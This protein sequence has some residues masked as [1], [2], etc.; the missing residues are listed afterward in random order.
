MKVAFDISLLGAEER[1]PQ[2]RTGI[3]KT[4]EAL[5]KQLIVLC[6]NQSASPEQ[7]WTLLP[8]SS[9]LSQLYTSKLAWQRLL[10]EMNVSPSTLPFF[11][12]IQPTIIEQQLLALQERKVHKKNNNQS[13]LIESTILS[14]YRPFWKRHLKQYSKRLSLTLPP[15]TVVHIPFTRDLAKLPSTTELARIVTCYDLTPIVCEAHVLAK[16]KEKARCEAMFQL[17]TPEDWVCCISKSAQQD[18]LA[19]KP[20]LSAHRLP[21]TY[22]G[23]ESTQFL[24]VT[25]PLKHSTVR[26][27]YHIPADAQY[28]LS[29]CTHLPHKNIPFLIRNFLTLCEKN[30]IQPNV[31][32]VLC[33]GKR[34]F[35]AEMDAILAQFPQHHHR[36]I[37]TGYVADEDLPTLYSAA[38]AFIL[39]SLYEGFGLP[40]LEA[41]QC[42]TPVLCSN[43]ASLPEV[44]GDA[45]LY[46]SPTNDSEFQQQII[47]LLNNPSLRQQL[48]E[49]GFE[50]AKTFSW[51][52]CAEETLAVYWQ[53]YESL[54]AGTPT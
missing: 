28:L 15:K 54:L 11:E 51:A 16:P 6:Q 1:N 33:G 44:G 9:D 19:F 27:Q 47:T 3:Y 42:G 8:F 32:L 5:L 10:Q 41:M 31:V 26:Q 46:A 24:S 35:T 21:V 49:K 12:V 14:A 20:V 22:L 38:T 48:I 40:V 53:A 7:Q 50:Q 43:T 52:T 45:A 2:N 29:V 17:I 13:T 23:A 39:P 36:V 4:V 25:D 18:L 30:D 37:V 34:K